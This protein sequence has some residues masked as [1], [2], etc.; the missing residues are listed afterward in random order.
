MAHAP[1][2]WHLPGKLQWCSI[3][4]NYIVSGNQRHKANQKMNSRRTTLPKTNTAPKNR[5]SQKERSLPTTIFWGAMLVW[6]RVTQK[7]GAF[8]NPKWFQNTSPLGCAVGSSL[9]SMAIIYVVFWLSPKCNNYPMA[10]VKHISGWYLPLMFWSPLILCNFLAGTWGN[11][12][13]EERSVRFNHQKPQKVERPA[14]SG[15]L[16]SI[17]KTV[18]FN[19]VQACFSPKISIVWKQKYIFRPSFVGSMFAFQGVISISACQPKCMEK[20]H[21]AKASVGDLWGCVFLFQDIPMHTIYNILYITIV[22]LVA[23]GS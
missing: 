6:G 15:P 16:F 8:L 2:W 11:I 17:K 4:A 14:S 10:H 20:I 22:Y 1:C 9:G 13:P 3:K 7:K 18:F 5:P 12:S 23:H 19:D 21:S